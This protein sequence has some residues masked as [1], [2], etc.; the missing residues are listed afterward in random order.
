MEQLLLTGSQIKSDINFANFYA[1]DN[2]MV[3]SYLSQFISA[4]DEQ[5]VYI[6]GAKG[7]GRSH[8]LQ[9]LINHTS[10][11][12]LLGVYL[13]MMHW[14]Q[15][16]PSLFEGLMNYAVVC[17]DDVDAIVG[18]SAWEIG[19]FNLFNE[20]K[21]SNTKLVISATKPP[22]QLS[23]QLADLASRLASGLCLNLK[24]L[25]DEQKQQALHQ[26]AQQCGFT[27]PKEVAKYLL[28][29]Y[30]REQGELFATL[31]K[32][33]EAS[34]LAQRKITIPFLKQTLNQAI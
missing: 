18:E 4:E 33:S 17:L 26:R 7:S 30:G 23:H 12:K 21:E 19:L 2:A 14:Q 9:A 32:L 31:E 6:Y 13:P 34:L 10:Q 27:L 1:G 25:T 20:L 22:L 15:L 24:P 16:E 3:I 29:H 8:L 11:N 28:T 5:Y